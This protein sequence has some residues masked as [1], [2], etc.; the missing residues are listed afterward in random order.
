M[1]VIRNKLDQ[2]LLINLKS[3]VSIDLLARGTSV[4]SEDDYSSEHLQNLLDKGKII[5]YQKEE[6]ITEKEGDN[7]SDVD[8]KAKN[9]SDTD[10]KD[11]NKPDT[12]KKAKTEPD[13]DKIANIESD[14]E[15]EEDRMRF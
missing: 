10:K 5:V 2:R 13:T 15:I 11:K 8:K 12:D 1:V 7:E 3:G 9:K 6:I 14:P 4:V